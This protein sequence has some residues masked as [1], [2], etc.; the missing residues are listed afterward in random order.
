MIKLALLLLTTLS[1]QVSAEPSRLLQESPGSLFVGEERQLQDKFPSASSD[2]QSGKQE[3]SEN[4]FLL[5][6]KMKKVK[7]D[8]TQ[9]SVDC[10]SGSKCCVFDSDCC[11]SGCVCLSGTCYKKM[12]FYSDF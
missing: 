8:A 4:D 6:V 9:K 3:Q 7:T 11:R 5:L 10:S 1:I 12:N 2:F